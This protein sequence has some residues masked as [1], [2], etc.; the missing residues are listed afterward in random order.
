MNKKRKFYAWVVR[1]RQTWESFFYLLSVGEREKRWGIKLWV[2]HGSKKWRNR[3][4]SGSKARTYTHVFG[5]EGPLRLLL[6]NLPSSTFTSHQQH[7]L[8]ALKKQKFLIASWIIDAVWLLIIT[9]LPYLEWKIYIV[10]LHFIA[11]HIQLLLPLR[12]LF[13]A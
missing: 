9:Q 12:N 8:L 11:R 13:Q 4:E 10:D 2:Q 3:H 6:F 5:K 7:F 1:H